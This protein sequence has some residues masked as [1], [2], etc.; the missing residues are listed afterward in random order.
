MTIHAPLPGKS[1]PYSIAV[2]DVDGVP[3]RVLAPVTDAVAGSTAI[4]ARGALVLR[5]MA[6]R[7]GIPDYGYAFQPFE[8]SA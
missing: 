7:Q 5:R 1:T 2:V 6:E 8:A 3:L 4:G